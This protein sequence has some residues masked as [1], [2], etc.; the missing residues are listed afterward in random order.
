MFNEKSFLKTNKKSNKSFI[1]FYTF[2]II[3]LIYA[4]ALAI[5]IKIDS[6]NNTKEPTPYA[7][8]E[9]DKKQT[10]SSDSKSAIESYSE[11]YDINPIKFIYSY[12]IDGH[13]SN[14]DVTDNKYT[15]RIQFLQVDG[16]KNK[17]VQYSIN[18]KIKQKAYALGFNDNNVSTVVTANY[19]NI[20]SVLL[21]STSQIDTV[22]VDLTT[23]NDI[24]LSDVFTSNT[25]LN[26]YLEQDFYKALIWSNTTLMKDSFVDNNL[27][28]SMVDTSAYEDKLIQLINNYNNSKDSLKFNITENSVSI[29]GLINK[30]MIDVPNVENYSLNINLIDCSNEVAI[31]K[32]YIKDSN[33]YENSS[34]GLNNTIVLTKSIVNEPN[35][36]RINYGKIADN[37]FVEENLYDLEQKPENVDTSVV[38]K[39]VKNL[40][41][42]L[43]NNLVNQTSNNRGSFYQ[44]AYTYTFDKDNNYFVITSKSYQA[45]CSLAYF[46][47]DA[48]LDYIKLKARGGNGL[49]GF[50]ESLKDNFPNLEI[51]PVVNEEYYLNSNG[52]FLGKNQDEAKAKLAEIKAQQELNEQLQNTQKENERLQQLLNE[53]QQSNNT[54]DNATTNSTTNTTT[55]TTTNNTTH[56]I[57]IHGTNTFTTNSTAN[58]TSNT[59]STNST[60]NTTLNLTTNSNN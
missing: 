44:R 43:R 28:M 41:E 8:E 59:A 14:T 40:S 15:Y 30:K 21:Y 7:M 25:T 6:I 36:S 29:Y 45:M 57:T 34:L 4:T 19:A 16:L 17:D 46:K 42:D 22:N 10:T 37:I 48:F 60:T 35:T 56:N 55:N 18:E 33:I 31:Y 24:H 12:D 58:T 2:F 27:D 9:A 32:R 39:Y 47:S 13:V 50:E 52:E 23:G 53:A 11:T 54:V 51:L 26:S 5:S 3:V 20:L 49:I 38:N 1:I